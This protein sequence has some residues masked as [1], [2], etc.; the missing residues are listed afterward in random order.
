MLEINLTLPIMMVLFLIFAWLMNLVFFGPVSKVLEERREYVANQQAQAAAAL[1]Q[2]TGLQ[3]DYDTR[4]KAAHA[5][6]QEAIQTAAREAEAKRQALLDAV[7]SDIEKEVADARASIQAERSAA[8]ASLQAEVGQ[9]TD[10]IKRKVMVG[11]P[12]YSSAGGNEA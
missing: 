12:A 2:V 9:F 5:Q 10:L 11:S 6:A 4:L 8:V 1:A 7:K 3:A